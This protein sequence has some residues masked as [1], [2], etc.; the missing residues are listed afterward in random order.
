MATDKPIHPGC[1]I[2]VIQRRPG[3]RRAGLLAHPARLRWYT[4]MDSRGGGHAGPVI[5]GC[6]GMTR[7]ARVVAGAALLPNDTR[8]PWTSTAKYGAVLRR[9]LY[10]TGSAGEHRLDDEL[11]PAPK[12]QR[13][14]V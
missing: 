1:L 3:E 2:G 6:Q 14:L 5:R 7:R 4:R 12:E 13:A 9:P 11:F 8:G 10:G